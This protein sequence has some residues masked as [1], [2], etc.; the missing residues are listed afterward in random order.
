MGFVPDA[1]LGIIILCNSEAET[2]ALGRYGLAVALGENPDELFPALQLE[3]KLKALE[4]TYETYKGTKGAAR[5]K[6]TLM[7]MEFKGNLGS[8]TTQA[9]PGVGRRTPFPYI[10]GNGYKTPH[11]SASRTAGGFYSHCPPTGRCHDGLSPMSLDAIDQ[12]GS[13]GRRTGYRFRGGLR[14]SFPA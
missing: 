9:L 4:G 13:T 12:S 3:K 8:F 14:P 10:D 2:P 1:G 6:D 5:R 11:E 7:A